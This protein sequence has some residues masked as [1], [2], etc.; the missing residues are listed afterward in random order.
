MIEQVTQEKPVAAAPEKP[1]ANIRN[2]LVAAAGVAI[3]GAIFA[4]GLTKDGEPHG[5]FASEAEAAHN[6]PPGSLHYDRPNVFVVTGADA[7]TDAL[8]ANKLVAACDADLLF[9]TEG[10]VP[11]ATRR[12]IEAGN[13][14][15]TDTES[16]HSVAVIL[17]G[18]SQVGP[19]V[20]AELQEYTRTIERIAGTNRFETAEQL[21]A[22]KFKK[23]DCYPTAI[24]P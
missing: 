11:A 9:A 16:R 19:Q 23:G 10:G 4:G 5:L 1:P 13:D 22:R 18:E 8:L 6:Y 12:A 3:A 15:V 20:E 21:A 14:K 2:W 17:G 24:I 7:Q